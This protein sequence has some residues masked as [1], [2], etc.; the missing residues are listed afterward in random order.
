[1]A[2]DAMV[3]E[4]ERLEM[5]LPVFGADLLQVE[6]RCY[7]PLSQTAHRKQPVPRAW[8]RA[9]RMDCDNLAKLYLDAAN[10]V[11]WEDDSQVVRLVVERWRC[12]QGEAART[13]MAVEVVS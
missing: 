4:A 10:S 2:R 6:L 12:A 5:P 13:E 8:L 9:G 7:F 1:L 3:R 11:F